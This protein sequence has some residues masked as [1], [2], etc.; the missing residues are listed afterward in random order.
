[1]VQNLS[2][3]IFLQE[4]LKFLNSGIWIQFHNAS[5]KDTFLLTRYVSL[6]SENVE[7]TKR[8]W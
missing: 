6:N 7:K 2:W 1:M 8:T 5:N 4:Q 3:R